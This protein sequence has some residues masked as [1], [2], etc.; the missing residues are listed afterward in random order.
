ME[1]SVGMA[2]PQW[3]LAEVSGERMKLL[4]AILR[5]PN[6]IHWDAGEVA[7]RGLGERTINQ[8]PSNL[9][10][11]VNML[12]AW[13]G[14]TSLRRLE[15]RFTSNVFEGERVLA[16]GVVTAVNEEGHELLVDCDVWLDR[17]DGTRAV[18][19]TATVAIAADR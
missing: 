10:Y 1:V 4:A 3:S 12:M 15:A 18:A 9:G 13:A 7:R 6:P 11:V 16:G 17:G 14:P 2:L 5:D 8:G 19:A